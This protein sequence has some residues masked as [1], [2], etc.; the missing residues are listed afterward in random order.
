LGKNFEELMGENWLSLKDAA[1]LLG[2][3]PS[4]LRL[5]SN[6][7]LLPVHL[8]PGGHRRYLRSEVELWAASRKTMAPEEILQSVIR[9]VRLQI[10]EGRLDSESWYARLDEMARAQYRQAAHFLFRGLLISL[11]DGGDSLNEAHAIGY[12]YASR[13]RRYGLNYVE[14]VRAFLFFR[15]SMMDAILS[16]YQ[17]ANL[18]IQNL[19]PKIQTFTDAILLS[20]IETYQK[21]ENGHG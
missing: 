21:F 13:A 8:T 1:A 18:P 2:V 20:L 9:S 11:S 12:E 14:A 3:H 7:G 6:K 15:N 19:L 10:S 4:T 16:V 5:W 17:Q